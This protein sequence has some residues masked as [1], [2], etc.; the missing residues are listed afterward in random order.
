MKS[1]TSVLRA[2]LAAPGSGLRWAVGAKLPRSRIIASSA[3]PTS[4]PTVSSAELLRRRRIRVHELPRRDIHADPRSPRYYRAAHDEATLSCFGADFLPDAP[5]TVKHFTVSTAFSSRRS[6]L[7]IRTS[8]TAN[9]LTARRPGS[10]RFTPIL[11]SYGAAKQL[12]LIFGFETHSTSS[13]FPG[14]LLIYTDAAQLGRPAARV[15]R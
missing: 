4:R 11:A 2:K 10:P 6:A 9:L 15:R 12:A 7:A 5:T 8:I 3:S 1:C 14:R 13:W